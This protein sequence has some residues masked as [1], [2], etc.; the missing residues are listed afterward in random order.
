MDSERRG[1]GDISAD[2]FMLKFNKSQEKICPPPPIPIDLTLTVVTNNWDSA[3]ASILIT[4]VI[5]LRLSVP[6]VV[7]YP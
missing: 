3:I 4:R 5:R 1:E 2:T 6:V 7:F